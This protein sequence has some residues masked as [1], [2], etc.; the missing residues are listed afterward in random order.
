MSWRRVRCLVLDGWHDG[1]AIGHDA[2]GPRRV[3]VP[4]VSRRKLSRLEPARQL[5][6]CYGRGRCSLA[7]TTPSSGVRLAE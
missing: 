2:P 3:A 4:R 7:P 6:R 5:V 1:Q